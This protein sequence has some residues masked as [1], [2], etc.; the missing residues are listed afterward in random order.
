MTSKKSFFLFWLVVAVTSLFQLFYV[1]YQPG[2]GDEGGAYLPAF[3]QAYSLWPA[4]DL[5]PSWSISSFYLWVIAGLQAAASHPGAV[6]LLVVGRALSLLCWVVLV[7]LHLRSGTYKALAVLFN[8]YV[9]IYSV[10]AHPFLPAVLLFYFFW[11]LMRQ[12]K[13]SGTLFLPFA[14]TFQVFLG[15]AIGL[16][17]PR[18]PVQK[19][20]VVRVGAL[21]LVALSG[22]IITWLAWGGLYPPMFVKHVFF[23]TYHVNGHPSFGYL[24]T[25]PMLAGGVCWLTGNRTLAEVRQHFTYTTGVLLS[26]FVAAVILFFTARLVSIAQQTGN[27]ATGRW[28]QANWVMAYALIGAGW[29]RVHRDQYPLFFGLLGSAVLLVTLPYLYERISVFATVAPCLAWCGMQSNEEQR[30]PL[31]MTGC[32][33]FVLCFIVYQQYGSL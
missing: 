27:A 21:G 18:F 10:R 24:L 30:T 15:G 4:L 11:V 29:L 31:I 22:I 23:Q 26:L 8:P 12:N 17:T 19:T 20:D 1:I 14:V 3:E 2:R 13:W 6:H 16:F 32:I 5:S 9:L 33:F 25:V 7:L 28:G